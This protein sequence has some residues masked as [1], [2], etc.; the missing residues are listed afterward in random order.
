MAR[1]PSK[2]DR[3][4]RRLTKEAIKASLSEIAVALELKFGER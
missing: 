2:F 1:K 3:E 4:I